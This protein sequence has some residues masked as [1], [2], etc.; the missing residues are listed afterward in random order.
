M[1]YLRYSAKNSQGWS[2][3]PSPVTPILMASAPS[4]I[5]PSVATSMDGTKVVATWTD[6]ANYGGLGVTID[7]YRVK[8]G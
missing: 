1:Y 2:T 8:F 5:T 7:A 3:L 4:K 6:P